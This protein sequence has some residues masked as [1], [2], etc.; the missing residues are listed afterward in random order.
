M[1]VTR[2]RS[3]A[4]VTR[5]VSKTI[6]A[7]WARHAAGRMAERLRG[8]T[9]ARKV[10]SRAFDIDVIGA[11]GTIF[12]SAGNVIAGQGLDNLPVILVSTIGADPDAVP[13]LIEWVAEEQVLTG[14]FRPVV[15]LDTDRFGEARQ[16]G[17]PVEYVLPRTVWHGPPD[18]WDDYLAAR[19]AALRRFYQ[20]AGIVNLASPGWFNGAFLQSFGRAA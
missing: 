7:P 18:S 5:L 19:V 1:S 14:G 9:T 16:Y 13:G 20:A 8:S 10:V 17:Y 11:G 15:I 4:I 2:S 12:L 3:G 6:R